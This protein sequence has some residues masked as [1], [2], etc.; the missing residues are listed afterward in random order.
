MKLPHQFDSWLKR[1]LSWA[2]IAGGVWARFWLLILGGLLVLGSVVL[3]W[4]QSPF[5]HNLSGLQLSL[6]SDPGINPH[7]KLLSVGVLGV[8]VLIAGILLQRTPAFLALA[9][10]VL[11]MLWSITPAQIAFRQPSVL[12]RLTYELQVTP[13]E[14]VF[15]K[16]Y[17]VENYGSPELVPKRLNLESALGRFLAAWSFLRIGWYAF[18]VGAFLMFLHAVRR[19]PGPWFGVNLALLGLSVGALFIIVIPAAIGQYFYS[20]GILAKA[21]GRSQQA[22]ADFRR[23][24]RWDAWHAQD[25]YLYATIGRLQKEAGIASGSPERN[26]FRASDLLEANEYEQAIFELS[27][28]ADTPGALGVTAR[29]EIAATRVAFGFALYRSGG[30]GGAVRNWELA[31]AEDPTHIYA[32][33]YLA[34]GYYDLGRYESGLAAAKRLAA[35]IKDHKS[36]VADV[37]SIAGDCYA[38]LGNF[39]EARRFYQL[40]LVADPILNYW[41]LTRLAGE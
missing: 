15:T 9:A 10:A 37:Y 21:E 41:A 12:R 1:L 5:S 40:S 36:A 30:I 3:K 24:M 23:A 34:R 18:G 20:R 22:I 35:L 26:V 38:R 27:K 2:E 31:L 39:A 28:A 7:I 17:L 11:I 14:R 8:L 4:V 16:D 13:V 6:V 19:M 32:L 29:Q 25:I 33:P